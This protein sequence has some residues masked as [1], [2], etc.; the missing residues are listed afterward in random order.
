M[1]IETT[2]GAGRLSEY[3]LPVILLVRTNIAPLSVAFF[4]AVHDS[5]PAVFEQ[6]LSDLA[7]PPLSI[8]RHL[9]GVL[10][11]PV[12]VVALTIRQREIEWVL[13]R[14]ELGWVVAVAGVGVINAPKVFH[15]LVVPVR[16]IVGYVSVLLVGWLTDPKARG[17]CLL[18][19]VPASWWLPLRHRP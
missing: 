12:I 5:N 3:P 13:L 11:Q 6:G 18:H 8:P 2:L 9:L 10:F 7:L 16:A 14:R 4:A 17:P 19:G 1:L 15:P